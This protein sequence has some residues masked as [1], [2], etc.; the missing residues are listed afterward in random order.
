M[1]YLHQGNY[2]IGNFNVDGF[3]VAMFELAAQIQEKG[4][5]LVTIII[6]N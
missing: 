4:N 6:E 1:I 5:Y 3:W 2:F